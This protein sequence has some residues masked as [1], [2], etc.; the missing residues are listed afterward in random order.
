MVV[1]MGSRCFWEEG[2][3]G[4][5]D[6]ENIMRTLETLEVIEY[7]VPHIYQLK[8]YS[9]SKKVETKSHKEETKP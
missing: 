9:H 4:V 1:N 2:W 3:V 7:Q 6:G 8:S 5:G